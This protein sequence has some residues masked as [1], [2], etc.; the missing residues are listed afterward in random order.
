VHSLQKIRSL[1]NLVADKDK[2]IGRLSDEIEKLK[3]NIRFTRVYELEA[4]LKTY[5][6][7]TVRLKRMIEHQIGGVPDF[8]SLLL[9]NNESSPISIEKLKVE[10]VEKDSKISSLENHIKII[11]TDKEESNRSFTGK[12]S[13]LNAQ[14]DDKNAN[15]LVKKFASLERAID[16]SSK[17]IMPKNRGIEMLKDDLSGSQRQMQQLME[18]ITLKDERLAA[19]DTIIKELRHKNDIN[20]LKNEETVQKYRKQIQGM[21][22]IFINYS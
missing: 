7:E 6:R 18:K 8:S 20:E 17:E 16:S 14:P 10:L 5:Y 15:G 2:A 12:F 19:N 11:L 13:E 9:K 3:D 22:Y 1:K 21:F 4:E